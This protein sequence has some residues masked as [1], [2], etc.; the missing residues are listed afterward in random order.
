[1]KKYIL[2]GAIIIWGYKLLSNSVRLLMV[3]VYKA[4]YLD[5]VS[6]QNF[7]F[8]V[9]APS[10]R[11]LFK[12]AGIIEALIPICEP[13]GWGKLFTGNAS[14]FDNMGYL[15]E[16]VP[17]RMINA[18]A[19]AEGTFRMRI[20]ECFSPLY[21]IEC[22]LFL[23]KKLVGYLGFKEDGIAAKLL[24]V[25]YWIATPVFIAVR[26]SIYGYITDLLRNIQ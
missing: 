21:W 13:I 3:R 12:C 22:I 2:L 19:K 20:M 4:K 10:I 8:S 17:P 7:N 1:M 24:Q 26:T 16:D 5:Y 9:Y 11:K 14:L 6:Q 18:F 15:R 23:P 25:I